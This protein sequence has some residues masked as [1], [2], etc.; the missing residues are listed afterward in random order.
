MNDSL[1][2][3]VLKAV[4]EVGYDFDLAFGGEFVFVLDDVEEGAPIFII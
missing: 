2:S 3:E 4:A 1:D